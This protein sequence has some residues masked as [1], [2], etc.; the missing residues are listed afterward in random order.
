VKVDLI[1]LGE[2]ETPSEWTLGDQICVR[3][4]V[5]SVAAL[6]EKRLGKSPA[7]LWLFWDPSLGVPDP[8]KVLEAIE[9]PGDVWHAGLRLGMKGLPQL[10]DTVAPTWMLNRDPDPGIE[11]TSWRLSLRACLIKA[12]VIRQMGWVNPRFRT[13]EAAALEMGHRFV[14][15][16]VFTRHIPWLLQGYA[17]CKPPLLPFEDELRFVYYRYGFRWALWALFRSVLRRDVSLRI[18]LGAWRQLCREPVPPQPEPYQR[19]RLGRIPNVD[20]A[21]VS[22][23]IPTVDRYPYLRQVLDQLRRQTIKPYEVIVVDQ[24]ARAYRDMSIGEEFKDL[25]LKLFY[26]EEAGQCSSRNLGLQAAAGEWILFLDD[27]DEVPPELIELHLGGALAFGTR[28]SNGVA[29]VPEEGELPKDYRLVRVSGVFPTNNSLVHKNVLLRSGLFDLAYDRGQRADGDLGMRVYL[30][31]ELMVLNPNAWVI[32]H[33]APSGGLRKHKARVVTY[34]SS[35]KYLTHRNLASVWD[36]YLAKR[37]FRDDQVR[38]MLWL[39]VLGTFSIRGSRLRRLLKALM[40]LACLPHTLWILR[41]RAFQAEEMLNRY[42]QIPRLQTTGP[43]M[44]NNVASDKMG[45]G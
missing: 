33:H 21:K 23:L 25:P 31:G 14:T 28:V 29:H 22:V 26:L 43:E 5:T 7:N 10:I 6:G 36:L 18:A 44:G 27:D 42:P 45:N 24:T 19:Q 17:E 32:H 35:R 8:D 1:I 38:E 37:Y 9:R 20:G 3:P 13:V 39:D 11:A 40:S 34:A 12:D 41:R 16:G 2:E 15:R 4:D 30:T